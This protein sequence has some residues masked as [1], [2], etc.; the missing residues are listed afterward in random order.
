MRSSRQARTAPPAGSQGL[1][2]GLASAVV[3]AV[4][5]VVTVRVAVP[6]VVPVI[7]TGLVVPKL[8]VGALT[9][10]AGELVIAA[11]RATLPV[12][13]PLGV[14]VMVEVFPVVAPATTVTAVSESFR[15]GVE[16]DV[17]TVT[18]TELAAVKVPEVPVTVMV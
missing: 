13:P 16:V 11:V 2:A 12:N 5:L 17:V 9:A 14:T 15:P 7:E 1:G 8:R 6:A 3:V 10:L 18:E 4:A